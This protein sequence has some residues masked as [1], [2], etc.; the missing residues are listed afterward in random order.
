MDPAEGQWDVNTGLDAIL[1]IDAP[2]LDRGVQKNER[3]SAYG[4]GH[5]VS[6]GKFN[7][8][9]FPILLENKNF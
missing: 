5:L 2:R 3:P 7:I 1:T 6:D 8:Y 9:I 4:G